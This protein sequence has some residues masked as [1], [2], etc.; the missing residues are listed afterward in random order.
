MG[1]LFIDTKNGSEQDSLKVCE[2]NGNLASLCADLF[3]IIIRMREAEDLGEPSA[4]RKLIRYYL[5]LFMKKCKMLDISE[6]SISEV[7]YAITA[8]VDETVLSI[9]GICRD[10]W[11]KRPLQIDYYG[12][13]I[14]G[15]E[16]FN[17]LQKLLLQPEK[18]KDVLEIYY[19]CLSLGFE[20]RYKI[21]RPEERIAIMED[22]WRILHG[23]RHKEPNRILQHGIED[24]SRALSPKKVFYFPAVIETIGFTII[25]GI[26]Y[27]VM[28]FLC[29][30][31]LKCVLRLL[32]Q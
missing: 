29:S 20:G 11:I 27:L 15:T 13:N 18:K 7:K 28:Y 24:N 25:A 9:E 22:V 31:Q 10:Y 14:A 2:N 8:L 6:E 21:T 4:L 1:T 19:L 30:S 32:R 23:M 17:R 5:D 12:D 16:F 26:V 3:L